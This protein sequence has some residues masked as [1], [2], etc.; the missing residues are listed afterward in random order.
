M[1]SSIPYLTFAGGIIVG[2]IAGSFFYSE[3]LTELPGNGR[4]APATVATTTVPAPSGAVSVIDQPAG[5]RVAVESVTVPPPGVW[6]AVRETKQT[7]QDLGYILGAV[8]VGG[9]RSNVSVPLLRP[10]TPD[11]TYAVELY[12][13]DA[14]GAF[15]PGRNS[16]Y[17]DPDTGAAAISYFKT[18]L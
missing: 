2:L 4:P 6:V 18:T 16:V 11:R 1:K 10:T 5:D 9:P 12:R 17:V 8:K 7:T 14:G 3:L 13:D 15:D